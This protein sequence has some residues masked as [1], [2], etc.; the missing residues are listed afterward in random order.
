VDG[1][2]RGIR[3]YVMLKVDQDIVSESTPMNLG[4]SDVGSAAVED[5][6]KRGAQLTPVQ[7]KIKGLSKKIREAKSLL[8]RVQAGE[9]LEANQLQKI[10][11][12]E[13][14]EQELSK[15]EAQI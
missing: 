7:K 1:L 5:A 11:N 13:H 8:T 12:L 14:W 2:G 15:L 6:D 10:E 9:I 3:S 4:V